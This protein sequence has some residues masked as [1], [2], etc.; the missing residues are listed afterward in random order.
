MTLSKNVNGQVLNT[1][2]Q[3]LDESRNWNALYCSRLWTDSEFRNAAINKDICASS[4]LRQNGNQ[5]IKDCHVCKKNGTPGDCTFIPQNH[6]TPNGKLSIGDIILEADH[7]DTSVG[8][9][10][11]SLP[12]L[13]SSIR[14]IHNLDSDQPGIPS[15]SSQVDTGCRRKYSS[16]EVYCSRYKNNRLRKSRLKGIKCFV[17]LSITDNPV[18]KRTQIQACSI[19][20]MIVAI[21]IISFVLVHF[22][23]PSDK[24]DVFT[25]LEVPM[26]STRSNL[27]T[28]HLTEETSLA[29]TE[30]INVTNEQITTETTT[31]WS[32]T[33][34]KNT[35]FSV[36]IDRIR[37]SL[38][39]F[40]KNITKDGTVSNNSMKPKEINNRD[41][42]NKFCSCQN[43]EVCMLQEST[44]T[45]LCRKAIDIEDPTGCGGLCALETEACQ[46]V[47]KSRGIRVCRQLTPTICDSNQ[48]RCRNGLCVSANARCDGIIQCYDRSDEMYCDCDL[49]RN[50][51]CGHAT[52][53]FPNTKLCDGV[54]DCWDGHDE[55]NCTT[56]CPGRQFTCTDGECI[57]GARFCDGLADCADGSDEPHGC[58]AACG[59][60]EL[61]CRNRRC[62]PRAARC[63]GYDNCGDAT[64]EMHCS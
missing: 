20:V 6:S 32:S 64:D 63:D 42:T 24:T 52:S 35:E 45:A 21:V 44:G 17:S 34:Q 53:C 49:K 40:P 10:S 31:F 22:T 13:R 46:V 2:P 38:K 41:L 55:V 29:I 15:I 30:T 27:T 26:E 8:N 4:N 3:I 39:T 61:R 60:H 57:A 50:F 47:D 54:I 23:S 11:Y 59:A 14:E 33:T 43:D 5:M 28:E 48:W 62:V 37:Q 36:I 1:A 58:D 12:S 7:T 25:K 18:K 9:M 56:E 51:R 16:T 19:S